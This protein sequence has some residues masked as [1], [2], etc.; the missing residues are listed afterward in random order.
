MIQLSGPGIDRPDKAILSNW[1]RLSD[2]PWAFDVNSQRNFTL[3]PYSINDSAVALYW[4]PVSVARGAS[5]R[6]SFVMGNFNEKGYP[7]ASDK[8]STEEIFAST[9]LGS[10]APD[11]ATSMAADLVAARDLISRIDRAI[12]S[13]GTISDEELDAWRKILDRLEE[14]KKGY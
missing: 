6:L 2:S 4:E 13:G 3:V 11:A 10:G 5:R 12:A 8:T 1:K 9:V 14:R 7:A